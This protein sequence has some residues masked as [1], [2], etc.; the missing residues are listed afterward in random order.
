MSI[1]QQS[2]DKI[3]EL[4]NNLN[5]IELNENS[6]LIRGESQAYHKTSAIKFFG[7]IENN[8]QY[9]FN[10]SY[11]FVLKYANNNEKY[12]I[13][14]KIKK[15]IKLLHMPYLIIDSYLT[16]D[17]TKKTFENCLKLA[18]C[19]FLYYNISINE[20]YEIYAKCDAQIRNLTEDCDKNKIVADEK[21]YEYVQI[22]KRY[23]EFVDTN[24][25]QQLIDP[26]QLKLFDELVDLENYIKNCKSEMKIYR[27]KYCEDNSKYFA[28]DEVIRLE[29]VLHSISQL[30]VPVKH[31]DHW[32]FNTN[33]YKV[34]CEQIQGYYR[35]IDYPIIEFICSLNN[36][37]QNKINGWLRYVNKLEDKQSQEIVICDKQI[38]EDYIEQND[39]CNC[40]NPNNICVNKQQVLANIESVEPVNIDI[41]YHYND[42]IYGPKRLAK[43]SNLDEIS[44]YNYSLKYLNK[45]TD[46]DK[47]RVMTWNIHMWESNESEGTNFNEIFEH[48][49]QVN[50]DIICFQE[51]I[52]LTINGFLIYY[53][54]NDK[55][56]KFDYMKLNYLDNFFKKYEIISRCV[57]DSKQIEDFVSYDDIE[58]SI[59]NIV[60]RNKNSLESDNFVNAEIHTFV[61]EMETKCDVKCKISYKQNEFDLYNIHLSINDNDRMNHINNLLSRI[62]KEDNVIIMGD[63]NDYLKDDYDDATY[64]KLIDDKKNYTSNASGANKLINKTNDFIDVFQY[65]KKKVGEISSTYLN[66]LIPINTTIYGGRTDFI[67]LNKNFIKNFNILGGYKLYTNASDHSLLVIDFDVSKNMFGGKYKKYVLKK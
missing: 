60:F 34:S 14:Y 16:E 18:E 45:L 48:I 67:Y 17:Q 19:A 20:R 27:E 8:E 52:D 47:L 10:E 33:F 35:N 25:R 9:F 55:H 50:P 13:Y 24:Y 46:V 40:N 49:E 4:I 54:S 30:F 62:Q 58:I 15:N 39:I 21:Y 43:I 44:S 51:Y 41:I 23:P 7:Y 32:Y 6:C 42:N 38:F 37:A 5:Y 12:I 29:C 31:H 57:T 64:L 56:P 26:Q 22:Y 53:K 36:Y 63:F 28:R 59:E 1:N 65:I 66:Y 61:G 2:I 3:N 11:K